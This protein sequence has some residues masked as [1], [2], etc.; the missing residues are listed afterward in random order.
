MSQNILFV[1]FELIFI[2]NFYAFGELLC[3]DFLFSHFLNLLQ[4]LGHCHFRSWTIMLVSFIIELIDLVNNLV[5]LLFVYPQMFL[6]SV[7]VFFFHLFNF[8]FFRSRNSCHVVSV[9][10]HFLNSDLLWLDLFLFDVFGDL[11]LFLRTDLLWWANDLCCF[12]WRNLWRFF[13]GFD[14]SRYFSLFLG[15]RCLLYDFVA[16]QHLFHVI[17]D[18]LI[19]DFIRGSS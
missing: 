7:V 18:F 19:L 4:G 6:F 12:W 5:G 16:V 11:D 2:E 9:V 10:G 15:L 8:F 17:L 13:I 1:R 3:C 14:V